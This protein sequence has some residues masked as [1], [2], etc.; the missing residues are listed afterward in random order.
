VIHDT[1]KNLN[2]FKS[3]VSQE[4]ADKIREMITELRKVMEEKE[5]ADNIRSKTSEL[6]QTSLKAFEAVYKNAANKS[7]P[8]DKEEGKDTK[9]ADFKDVDDKEKK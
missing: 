5:D 4:D 8:E 6:Q 2:E 3:Q 9:D 7:A 1:E